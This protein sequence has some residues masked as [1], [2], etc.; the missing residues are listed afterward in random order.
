M[1]IFR[2]FVVYLSWGKKSPPGVRQEGKISHEGVLRIKFNEA[3][4]KRFV[5]IIMPD[6]VYGVFCYRNVNLRVFFVLFLRKGN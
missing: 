4:F 2:K 3:A 1:R 5:N 6:L